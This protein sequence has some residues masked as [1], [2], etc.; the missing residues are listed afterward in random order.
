VQCAPITFE[1][2][3]FLFWG[4]GGGEKHVLHIVEGYIRKTVC[5]AR[6]ASLLAYSINLQLQ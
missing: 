5:T 2:T 4:G 3:A 6:E 1:N